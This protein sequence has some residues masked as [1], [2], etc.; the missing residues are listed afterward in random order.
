M[1]RAAE[2]AKGEL[3][4]VV[5]VLKVVFIEGVL[6]K[7][8]FIEGVAPSAQTSSI[9]C[10]YN[11]SSINCQSQAEHITTPHC[12]GAL[13][14]GQ[15]FAQRLKSRNDVGLNAAGILKWASMTR[16]GLLHSNGASLSPTGVAFG[17]KSAFLQR[18]AHGDQ[19]N[20][21]QTQTDAHLFQQFSS[22]G[23]LIHF[24]LY[25]RCRGRPHWCRRS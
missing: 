1:V 25:S 8:V 12:A 2:Q 7:G 4:R 24:N 14:Q 3:E 15:T 5:V 19:W 18:K 9:P 20:S 21:A 11:R 13:R 17:Q 23:V 6:L 16:N 22:Q 10:A